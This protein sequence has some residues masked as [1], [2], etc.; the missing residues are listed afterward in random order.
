MGASLRG[1]NTII[2]N[3]RRT[4]AFVASACTIALAGQVAPAV[5]APPAAKGI[6]I[7][8]A[9][10]TVPVDIY[11]NDAELPEKADK[12]TKS[13][14]TGASEAT[15]GYDYDDEY[16]YDEYGYGYDDEYGYGYGDMYSYGEEEYGYGDDASAADATADAPQSTYEKLLA[17]GKEIVELDDYGPHAD[18]VT[19]DSS[20]INKALA[21]ARGGTSMTYVHIPAGNYALE[22]TVRIWPYTHLIVD[23]GAVLFAVQDDSKRGV[24]VS[25]AHYADDG[26]TRCTQTDDMPCSHGTYTQAHDITVEGGTWDANSTAE[27]TNDRA[28]MAFTHAQN[29]TIKNCTLTRC[30][31]HMILLSGSRNCVV[32]GC[33]FKDAVRR[34]G[35]DEKRTQRWECVH[36]DSTNEVTEAVKPFDNT[37]PCDIT[38]KD[39]TFTNVFAGVGCHNFGA[40]GLHE[41]GLWGR[42]NN[43]TVKGC[44]FEHLVGNCVNVY[45]SDGYTV[46]DN[47]ATDFLAFVRN[48]SSYAVVRNNWMS[49]S[50]DNQ[51]D[52]SAAILFK[53]YKSDGKVVTGAATGIIEGNIVLDYATCGISLVGSTA[54]VRNN[55]LCTSLNL[56]ANHPDIRVD[57][58]C[59]DVVIEGNA[60]TTRDCAIVCG[61]EESIKSK[62]KNESHALA[63]SVIGGLDVQTYTGEQICPEVTVTALD[64]QKILVEGTDYTV[65]YE[66]NIE[67]G[68]A[69]VRVTGMGAYT[70][71]V[72]GSFAIV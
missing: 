31:A 67:P 38:V 49:G 10:S 60:T 15:Y 68:T 13:S 69:T 57:T 11:T 36:L 6:V 1:G 4:A 55:Q 65:S 50:T 29:I 47:K 5:A 44:T 62:E 26:Y 2:R 27:P 52:H 53:D 72:L 58:Q 43:I 63:G 20:I 34:N 7:M 16:G 25:G 64:T 66:N 45:G 30:N 18:G 17:M 19:D 33:T 35:E 42:S 54:E 28:I 48:E 59:K 70:G 14:G 41:A 32:E 56:E 21:A 24:I 40:A 22:H 37:A 61:N 51:G 8:D 46:E 23:D 9:A 39:C 71:T 3:I 12:T